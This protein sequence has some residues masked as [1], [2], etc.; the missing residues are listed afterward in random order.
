MLTP[1]QGG[2]IY[3]TPLPLDRPS[4]F[5]LT[6]THLAGSLVGYLHP[7]L[8]SMLATDCYYFTGSDSP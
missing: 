2:G 5:L 7:H 8:I 3:C 6:S 4:A 1:L